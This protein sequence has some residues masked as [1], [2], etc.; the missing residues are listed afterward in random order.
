[1]RN[2]LTRSTL[3]FDAAPPL[4]CSRPHVTSPMFLR[5]PTGQAKND[6]G[7][8][9]TLSPITAWGRAAGHYATYTGTIRL[10]GLGSL[11]QSNRKDRHVVTGMITTLRIVPGPRMSGHITTASKD[12]GHSSN[13]GTPP[14][15]GQDWKLQP[16]LPRKDFT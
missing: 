7:Q 5:R 2:S 3:A 4:A 13:S 15:K 8:I 16:F 12:M 9:T 6:R 14:T 11:R 1:M 10:R